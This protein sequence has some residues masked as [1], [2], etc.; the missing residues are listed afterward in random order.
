MKTITVKKVERKFMYGNIKLDDLGDNYT[1]E[2]ILDHYSGFYPE[3]NNAKIKNTGLNDKGEHIY[4]F[5][6]IIGTKG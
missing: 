3:L 4:Q 1:P 6:T 5:E 2:M